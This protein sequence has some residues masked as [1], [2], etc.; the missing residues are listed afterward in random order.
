MAKR[1]KQATDLISAFTWA[2]NLIENNDIPAAEQLTLLHVI[3]RAN[4]AFWEPI[5]LSAA[6]LAA[7][8]CK[9]KR[10]VE[11]SLAALIARGAVV[12]RE[13]GYVIG[14]DNAGVGNDAKADSANDNTGED[15][16][17]GGTAR[18]GKSAENSAIKYFGHSGA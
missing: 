14:I 6:K 9:D 12:L 17:P 2:F 1:R 15:K 8:M 7:S 5:P 10:S 4:R 16:P 18:T 11:K 13:G 3:S